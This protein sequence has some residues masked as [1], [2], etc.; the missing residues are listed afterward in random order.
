MTCGTY[1]WSFSCDNSLIVYGLRPS[2]V[3]KNSYIENDGLNAKCTSVLPIGIFRDSE[4]T[5]TSDFRRT[6]EAIQNWQNLEIKT[7]IV[8]CLC[9][10]WD[11]LHKLLKNKLPD[12]ST[13]MVTVCQF[14]QLMYFLSTYHKKLCMLQQF[15]IVSVAQVF[16]ILYKKETAYL[17]TFSEEILNGKLHFLCSA[18]TNR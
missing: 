12:L 10:I 6:K 1:W 16:V 15:F 4:M 7:W 17:V 9:K 14:P 2:F 13:L 18:I 8:F 11:K 3:A 5:P